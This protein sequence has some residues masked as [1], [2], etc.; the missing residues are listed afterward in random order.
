MVELWFNKAK[1]V[2]SVMDHITVVEPSD[3]TSYKKIIFKNLNIEKTK[4]VKAILNDLM[5]LDVTDYE[6]D[7]DL[8]N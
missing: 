1:E 2:E 6:S 3:G 8:E 7:E 5:N 4:K